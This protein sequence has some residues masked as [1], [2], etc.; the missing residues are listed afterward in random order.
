M[1]DFHQTGVVPTLHRLKDRALESLEEDL[2]RFT[3]RQPIALV[4][5]ALYSEFEGEAMP[6]IL[7]E[8]ARAP[9]LN[10]VVVTLGCADVE[11]F[12]EVRRQVAEVHPSV[13]V[14]W[15]DGPRMQRIYEHL[16]EA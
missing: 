7:D 3:K 13:R 12:A 5:P 15:N 9:Y 1:A 4:L 14:I 6:R 8:I 2:R 10:Q 16:R 11:Q